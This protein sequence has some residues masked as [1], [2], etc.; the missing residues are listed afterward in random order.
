MLA[1]ALSQLVRRRR[2]IESARPSREAA[3]RAGGR[4]RAPSPAGQAASVLA[5][6]ET[7]EERSFP[8]GS[9]DDFA[10]SPDEGNGAFFGRMVLRGLA[11]GHRR[12]RPPPARGIRNLRRHASMSA[13]PQRVGTLLSVNVG[14]PKDVPWQG[15]TV[16]T[17]VFKDPVAGP[18]RVRKLNVDGDGQ[19]D[20]A[21]H[22]G[23]QRAVF[24][25]QIDSYRYWE[26][27]LGR[28]DFV[29]G[30]FGENFTIEGLSDDEVCIG[31]RYQIGTAVFEVTQ[32]RVTCYRVGIRMNDPRIPAL[33]V[34]HRRPGFY[35]RVLRR[36]RGPGGRRDPQARLGPGTDDG[37]RGRR[38]ALPPRTPAP[39]AAPSAADSCPQPGLASLVPR[40]ARRRT[41]SGNAGLA[42]ASP[43]PAWPGFRR[44]T[45]T[46]IE[47]RE[48]LRDLHPAR[49]PG[50][51]AAPCRTSRPVP[52]AANPTRRRAEVAAPQLLPL[53]TARCRLLPDH[54]QARTRRRR[55]RL[56]AYPARASATSSRSPHPVAPSSS[57]R[58]TRRCC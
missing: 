11:A 1:V 26:R 58:P 25:Y 24:V 38:A 14:L 7:E 20:L 15:R 53:G 49:R 10:A 4:A 33:L 40:P 30:Q 36:G 28:S 9:D 54:R 55:Q 2:A 23:E 34:S 5:C 37:R 45:V 8:D 46:G 43:P 13:A 19:G 51:R 16:F 56:S 52:H 50:R 44:L 12:L 3:G 21:G 41:R 29:Y 48:R 35:F 27:E 32:P 18:R 31:D 39:A 6:R 57:T 22:G 42:T 47:P 17:G